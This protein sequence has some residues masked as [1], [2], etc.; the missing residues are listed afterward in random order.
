MRRIVIETINGEDASR[1][2]YTD[3]LRTSFDVSPFTRFSA[4]CRF[5]LPFLVAASGCRFAG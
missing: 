3:A 4:F 1:S 2:P 5:S